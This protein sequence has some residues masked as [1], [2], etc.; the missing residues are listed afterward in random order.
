MSH[1]L[2]GRIAAIALLFAQG[3]SLGGCV[4]LAGFGRTEDS[5]IV[6]DSGIGF[7]VTMDAHSKKL[8]V[9]LDTEQAMEKRMIWAGTLGI[10]QG[11]PQSQFDSVASKWLNFQ[12][13]ECKAEQ[14]RR[15]SLVSYEY[16][17]SCSSESDRK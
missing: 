8:H 13:R 3:L 16:D 17:L 5:H 11:P 2:G 9:S 14:G 1:W 10:N 15:V 4:F 6:D 12:H 7:N